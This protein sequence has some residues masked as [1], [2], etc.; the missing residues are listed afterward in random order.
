MRKIIAFSAL[1]LA[2][3]H[4]PRISAALQQS[5]REM[6]LHVGVKLIEK[7]APDDFPAELKQRYRAFLPM[8]EEVAKESTTPRAPDCALTIQITPTVKEV[9][10]GKTAE[11]RVRAQIMIF[12]KGSP[13]E[14][15]ADLF[16]HDYI[17]GGLVSK[18]DTAKFL[19][20]LVSMPQ[21]CP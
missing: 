4:P 8:F 2:F 16:L 20:K 1:A 3:L 19:N 21:R 9:T 6:E 17:T 18:E 5:D 12:R 13:R 7:A 15:I 14:W 11:K 10:L